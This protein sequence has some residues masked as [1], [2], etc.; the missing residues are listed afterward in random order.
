M[1]KNNEKDPNAW[2]WTIV[3]AII[4]LAL[5]LYLLLGANKS[6]PLIVGYAL[7]IYLTVS[8]A[9]QTFSSLLNRDAAGSKTDRIRGL[10]G[11]V[12]G[13]LLLALTYF[14]ILTPAAAYVVLAVLL[15]AYGALGLFEV[16]FDRGDQRF[17]WMPLFIN[18]LLVALGVLAFVF[19]S[20]ELNLLTYSGLTLLL[21]GAVIFV[22]GFF[23][24]KPNRSADSAGV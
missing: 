21:I 22:Y 8:G 18:A 19:R 9:L 23:I 15:I 16:L 1:A 24:Q 10:V 5:G 13:G 6:A 12:G 20:S 2:I 7:A 4:A 17:N 3:R 14:G 11:L